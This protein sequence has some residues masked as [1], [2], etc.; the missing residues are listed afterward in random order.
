ML[1]GRLRAWSASRWRARGRADAAYHLAATF[2]RLAHAPVPL[3]RLDNHVLADQIAVT[4]HDLVLAE[5]ADVAIDEALAAIRSTR[6]AL[7]I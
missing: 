4:G 6:E 5:P 3:P 1:A 7:G 2:A